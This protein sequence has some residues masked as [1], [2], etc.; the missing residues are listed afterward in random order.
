MLIHIFSAATFGLETIQIDVEVSVQ[1]RG[2][3]GFDIVGL[4]DK[5]VV[6]SRERVRAAI[7]N[8]KLEFP[9]KKII[10]NLAPADIPKEG[11]FYDLPIALG[12]LSSFLP[13]S[14]PED[15]LFF[16]ELSLDGSLRHTRGAFLL[17]LFAKEAGYRHVFV[18][19]DSANE[20]AA[21]ENIAVYPVENLSQLISHFFGKQKIEEI[22]YSAP[23]FDGAAAAEFDMGEILGQ[24]QSK[25]ALEIAAAGAHNILF[26]GSPGA[27]KTMLAKALPGILPELNIEERFEVTK[28]YS[29][30]GHIPP[31]GGFIRTRQVRSP[32][33]TASLVGLMGGGQ[34]PQPGEVTLAHRGVLFLD[35]FTEFPRSAMEALRQPLEDG[36]I[37]IARSRGRIRYP[38]QCMLVASANPCPCGYFGHPNRQ[39]LCS[40]FQIA[41]YHKRISGPI[42]DRIDLH[43]D[44]PPVDL[45]ELEENQ[46][47]AQ[48]LES[49]SAIRERVE[50]ARTL[51]QKR[52]ASLREVS[53]RETKEAIHTN[54]Q[55]R[56]AQVKEYCAISSAGDRLL[57]QAGTRFQ[58][59][60]RSYMKV[61]KV[62]RTIADLEGASDVTLPHL[63]EALQYRSKVS[64]S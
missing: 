55:M 25:R 27:G 33:H 54:A 28:I 15:A 20:A 61:L 26:V 8:S 2:L 36:Y 51:Q 19:K 6:E 43:V 56:N 9:Q 39:C 10:V 24:E 7:V 29:A 44:V 21:V 41:R 4:G 13:L 53:R 57:Q 31:G 45:R 50:R 62:A 38:A 42:L 16:G 23:S 22:A 3:P 17:A 64:V 58:L 1:N 40:P 5:A 60:A 46:K 35:E 14:L 47:A 48:F 59:S 34:T 11:S 63:A 37:T 18:P 49:S 12:I 30:A 32:H 52:F